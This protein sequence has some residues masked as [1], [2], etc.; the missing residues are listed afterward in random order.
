[1][2]LIQRSLI[3]SKTRKFLVVSACKAFPRQS[4]LALNQRVLTQLND[5]L[6]ESYGFRVD[7]SNP[8]T[9]DQAIE[10][11]DYHT[12]KKGKEDR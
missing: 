10:A 3:S 1:M 9:I 4:E 7:Q 2:A 5:G 6:P 8:K 12:T 11:A